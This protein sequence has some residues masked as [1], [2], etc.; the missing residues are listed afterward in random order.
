VDL[1]AEFDPAAEIDL[2]RL[3]ALERRGERRLVAASKFS[4]NRA[5][6]AIA[7]AGCPDR[8]ATGRR[9]AREARART[10]ATISGMGTSFEASWYDDLAVFVMLDRH[11]IGWGEV[12]SKFG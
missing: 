11:Q 12:A 6:A 4:P 3:V 7:A 8:E 2:I 1:A 10:S 5:L 9:G